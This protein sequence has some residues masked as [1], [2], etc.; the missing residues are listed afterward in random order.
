ML[1]SP[2]CRYNSSVDMNS[3]EDFYFPWF[4][5]HTCITESVPLV[6]LLKYDVNV[7]S[8]NEQLHLFDG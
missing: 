4:I 7:I 2:A 5:P 8:F 6:K 3:P 1:D